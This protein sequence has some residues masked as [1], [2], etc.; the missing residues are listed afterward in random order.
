MTG[1]LC[2]AGCGRPAHDA[3]VCP[4]C[5]ADTAAALAEVPA[6]SGELDVTLA[7]QAVL[8][9][10]TDGARA[11][12]TP[13]PYHPAASEALGE[14]RAT[15]VGWT[16]LLAE[17][18]GLELPGDE[19]AAMSRWLFARSGR[20]RHHPAGGEAAGE[21]TAAVGRARRVI[22][23]PAPS[24]H[25]GVCRDCETAL[26][27]RTNAYAVVCR[28]CG[29][30]NDAA[31]RR[32]DMLTRL[33]NWLAPVPEIARLLAHLE[34]PVAT[35]TMYDYA[36]QRRILAKG[37]TGQQPMYR[38]GDVLDVRFGRRHAGVR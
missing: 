25:H 13:L 5:G 38:I 11:A 14:L 3:P 23:R 34:V 26:Y 21:I 4:A 29:E 31:E 24:T 32:A 19:V 22:D 30:V 1:P 36:A 27:G 2:A 17:E 9:D 7:R 18:S 8:S 35:S 10:R 33:D 16:R 12:E 20:L 28:N 15:L 37:H 6:L